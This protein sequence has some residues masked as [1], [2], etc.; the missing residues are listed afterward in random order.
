[1]RIVFALIALGAL[2]ACGVEGPPQP[3]TQT[4][5]SVT[6]TAYIGVSGQL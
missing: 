6:G 3:P 5:V 1:M 4:G 2:V